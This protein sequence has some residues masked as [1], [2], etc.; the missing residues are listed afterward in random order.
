MPITNAIVAPAAPSSGA[1]HQPNV[2]DRKQVERA[3]RTRARYKYVTP[4][5]KIVE[6]C[7]R[8]ESPCCSRR[9]DADGGV[10]DIAML[11]CARP[12]E[13]KLYCKDHEAAQWMLHGTYQWLSDLLEELKQDPQQKFWQ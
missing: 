13:W 8:I 7:F 3:L 6:G 12:G 10:V 5:V 11:L 2:F 9:V 4:A 1:I